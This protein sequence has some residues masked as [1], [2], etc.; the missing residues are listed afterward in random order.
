MCGTGDPFVNGIWNLDKP[1]GTGLF[2]YDLF[3]RPTGSGVFELRGFSG[4]GAHIL[5]QLISLLVLRKKF[6]HFLG[7]NPGCV[8][9]NPMGRIF[10]PNEA[11]A[12]NLA[13]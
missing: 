3:F 12:G 8:V 11:G 4:A 10:H 7:E 2:D 13:R 1:I 5:P 9:G 6:D